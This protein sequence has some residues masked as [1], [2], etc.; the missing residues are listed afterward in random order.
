MNIQPG[1]IIA[2]SASLEDPHFKKAV[3][4]IAEHNEKGALGF[5]INKPFPRALNELVEFRDSV[6]FPLFEGG[7]VAT[8]SLYFLHCRPD[9]IEGG[10]PVAGP[11]YMG[12]N[13]KQAVA[14][15]NNNSIQPG[16]I[17]IFIGYC[18]WDNNG[19]ED[20]IQEGSWRLTETG[21]RIAF[22][23]NTEK[24]WEEISRDN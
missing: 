13:F 15:I 9:M 6:A 17:K 23:Y 22:L 2:S 12:G 18:G 1:S 21:I 8:E 24:I 11:V 3:I 7:P 5:I 10:I 19:L 20:E 14:C 4:F 16:E